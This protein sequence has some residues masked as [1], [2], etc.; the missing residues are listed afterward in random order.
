MINLMKSFLFP[1]IMGSFP[2]PPNI[3]VL[4]VYGQGVLHRLQHTKPIKCW[5]CGIERQN[6]HELFCQQCK[7]IQS[8]DDEHNYF[9][10]LQHNEDFDI[11]L[12]ILRDKYRHMQSLLHPDKFSNRSVEEKN[13]SADF[14]SLVNNAYNVLQSPLKRAVHLLCLKGEKISED[15][16]IDD[17]EFLMEIME[18]NEEVENASDAEKLKELNSSNKKTTEKLELEISKYFK[19]KN[20]SKVKHCIIKLR[21]YNSISAHINNLMRERGIVE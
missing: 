7:I 1:K 8:P 11:D 12:D 18:L 5:K 2:K 4:S 13:I 15:E 16:R 9:K 3:N 14:S 21:Y 17:P 6:L 20:L 19:E 10:L